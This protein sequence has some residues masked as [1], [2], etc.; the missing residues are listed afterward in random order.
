MK[1]KTLIILILLFILFVIGW[2][3]T[4]EPLHKFL[5]IYNPSS[6]ADILIAEG[7]LDNNELE[8]VAQYFKKNDYQYLITTGYP[9]NQDLLMYKNGTYYLKI[10]QPSINN[11]GSELKVHLKGS[12]PY[13]H[14]SVFKIFVNEKLIALDSVGKQPGT[15]YYNLLNKDTIETVSIKFIN[16]AIVEGKD[17]N[18]LISS[19]SLNDQYYPALNTNATYTIQTMDD[20]TVFNLAG[21]EALLARNLLFRKGIPE[22]YLIAISGR[23]QGISKTLSTAKNTIEAIDSIQKTNEYSINIVSVPPHTRRTYTAYC[24]Y[25]PKD[26]IGIVA[27]PVSYIKDYQVNRLRNIRELL[28]ILFIKLH[29]ST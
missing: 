11:H 24:K 22:K 3:Y 13:K 5:S 16:D 6:K 14:A 18:L 23:K 15:F 4:G 27:V 12:L 10:H 1:N 26:S 28:G 8:F 9:L 20:S 21:T 19:V 2:F 25:H 29:P 17:R 7:W